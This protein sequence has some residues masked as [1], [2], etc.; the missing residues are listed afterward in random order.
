MQR[1]HFFAAGVS[2][3]VGAS[4]P[5][6]LLAADSSAKLF[7]LNYAPHFGMFKNS[8]PGGLLDELRFAHDQVCLEL[9]LAPARVLPDLAT[10]ETGFTVLRAVLAD[11]GMEQ[12]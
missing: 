11:H 9:R 6:L 5:S 12:V 2:A 4:L 1:R 8:A 7:A 3:A 10:C